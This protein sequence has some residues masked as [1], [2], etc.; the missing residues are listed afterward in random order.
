MA[1]PVVRKAYADSAE[2]QIHYRYTVPASTSTTKLPILFLHMSASS[3]A[4]FEQLMRI[5][6]AQ[7][8]A[9]YAPDMPGFGASFHPAQDPLNIRWYV[10]LYVDVFFKSGHFPSLSSHGCHVLGHHSGGV[11]GVELAIFHPHIV[12]SLAVVGPVLLDADQR[13]RA[14]GFDA[15]N[16]PVADGSHLARTWEYLQSHG[17]I[18]ASELGLLQQETLDH[19]RAWRG[20]LQIYSC[21]FGDHDGPS[22]YQQVKCPLITMCARDDVLWDGHAKIKDIR[23]DADAVEVKGANFTPS[24]DV[25][26]V[27]AHYTPFLEQ[28]RLAQCT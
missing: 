12:R 7:G 22:L 28:V 5:Y 10:D 15:F 6:S 14:R 4:T 25:E 27:A 13:E 3:S 24:R 2:G 16:K 26:G 19:A 18:T 21:V 11:I 20:R 23:P 1:A 9:C 17:G 8:H